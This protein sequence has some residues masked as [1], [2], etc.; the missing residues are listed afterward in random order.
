MIPAG[1]HVVLHCPVC[2]RRFRGPACPDHGTPT[3]SEPHDESPA[4]ELPSFPGL[5]VLGVL[6]RG[7][8]GVVYAAERED[9]RRVAVKTAHRDRPFAEERLRREAEALRRIGPPH[10]PEI[11]DE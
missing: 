6:G 8:F 1:S 2:G 11:L 3:T 7:G 4:E 5:R 9:G 10:V